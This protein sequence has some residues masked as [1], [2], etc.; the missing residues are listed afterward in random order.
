MTAFQPFHS[1]VNRIPVLRPKV[2]DLVDRK[3][4]PADLF[5]DQE[6][7]AHDHLSSKRWSG[8]IDLELTVRTPL[9]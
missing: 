6:P 8:S 2:L 5:G 3:A 7:P 4:L 9:V 1:A